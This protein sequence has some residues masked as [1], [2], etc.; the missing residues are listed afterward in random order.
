M[1]LNNN[2]NQNGNR[3]NEDGRVLMKKLNNYYKQRIEELKFELLYHKL[4]K[5]NEVK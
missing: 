2:N 4:Q 1:E 5:N 3:E